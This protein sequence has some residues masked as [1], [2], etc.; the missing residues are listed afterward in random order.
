MKHIT[1]LFV[2]TLLLFH[3]SVVHAEVSVSTPSG[4]TATS[5]ADTKES[6]DVKNIKEKLASITR[7]KISGQ[8]EVF[9]KSKMTKY[10][11]LTVRELSILLRLMNH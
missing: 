5:S 8:W 3:L 9:A 11:S 10:H 2:I 4:T 6:N 7:K 1:H